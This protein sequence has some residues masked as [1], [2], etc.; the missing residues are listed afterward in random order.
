MLSHGQKACGHANRRG[1]SRAVWADQSEDFS[2]R[3]RET[4]VVH[5]QQRVILLAQIINSIIGC[6]RN[7]ASWKRQDRGNERHDNY[8]HLT[9]RNQRA[10]RSREMLRYPAPTKH[11]C[12]SFRKIDLEFLLPRVKLIRPTVLNR[13]ET[14]CAEQAYCKGGQRAE[15]EVTLVF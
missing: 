12:T 9:I 14:C 15:A 6:T 1:L 4:N 7:S 8:G 10:L 13:K 5:G 2:L 11:L 3:Y